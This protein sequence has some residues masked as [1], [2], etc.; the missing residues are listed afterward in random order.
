[1]KRG[2]DRCLANLKRELQPSIGA[3]LYFSALGVGSVSLP[4]PYVGLS[5]FVTFWPLCEESA[6]ANDVAKFLTK[7]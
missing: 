3:T 4:L 7:E 6:S 1:M 2:S 5:W